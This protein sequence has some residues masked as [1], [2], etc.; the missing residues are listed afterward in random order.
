MKASKENTAPYFFKA[1]KLLG[2]AALFL[3]VNEVSYAQNTKGAEVKRGSSPKRE[4]RFRILPKKKKQKSG[5]GGTYK[6]VQGRPSP[7]NSARRMPSSK[8]R[9]VYPQR[10][11]SVNYSSKSDK[12]K[13]WKGD[14]TGR[15]IRAP[16]AGDKARKVY[17]QY[18]RYVNNPSRKSKDRERKVVSNRSKLARLNRMQRG[19]SGSSSGGK[20]QVVTPRSASRA[21]IARKSINV[22]ANFARPKPKKEKAHIKDI[23]GRRL[24]TKNFE[25]PKPKFS[26]PTF[27][28]YYGRKRVGDKVYQGR[29]SGTHQSATRRSERAWKGNISG[30]KIRGKNYSSKPRVEG[31]PIFPNKN[32]RSQGKDRRYRGS[33]PPSSGYRSATRS[34][35]SRT[36][37]R[38]LPARTPGAGA[39]RAGTY[40]GSI[41]IF[42]KSDPG[43]NNQGEGFAGYKKARRP[44]K[45]GGSVSGRLWNNR[46]SALPVRTPNKKSARAGKYQGSLKVLGRST[47]GYNNQGEGFTGYKKASRPVKGGGSVSGKLWNNRSSAIPVRTPN[48][49]SARAGKYQGSMKLLGRSNPGFNDQGEGFTGYKKASRP[50]KGGGSVSG[51]LWNNRSSAIPVRTPK[52]SAARVGKYQGSLKLLGKS[53]P[54]FNDQGEGFTGYK[55]AKK[56]VKG[57]GSVSGR[58]W[59]N[60]EKPIPVRTPPPEARR[61]GTFQGNAKLFEQNPTLQDQGEEF[62]G[63]IKLRKFR[64]NY[65]KNPNAADA[66]LKKK[67]PHKTTYAVDGLQVKVKQREYGKKPHAAEGSMPGIKPS[68][69]SVKASEYASGVKRTWKYIH[70]PSSADE[71]QRTR[72]PG[73]AFG[74]AT[75]YQGNIKMQKF[76][77]FEKNRHLHPDATFVK[78]NKNNVD[79]ERDLLTNV[80][81]WW[82]KLFKK[83]DTQPD[84]LKDKG[85]RPRYDKREDGLWYD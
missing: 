24:R 80:K 57:G 81:L 41:K 29:A 2:L 75:D 51:K 52:P 23:T 76:H 8:P 21:F 74:R 84:N 66:A 32:R 11:R 48:K 44:G 3:L 40:Q 26:T 83:Q 38:P 14:I 79:S 10:G 43:Y 17:P 1:W 18:G 65:V 71:A 25:T 5:G 33:M 12:Q 62:T 30:N 36:G 77:L 22:Y 6:R 53:N 19:N 67:H 7:A 72:E 46:L 70:N 61:A 60:K 28:P 85:K 73:K 47:P 4:N 63:F 34:G 50:V 9:K 39:A 42:G 15:K 54:G 68:K 13:A 20:K 64:K 55:K 78:T 27:K 58:L 56:P 37:K 69:S 59:N 49:K 16:R 45:G 82:A 31:L 35:E